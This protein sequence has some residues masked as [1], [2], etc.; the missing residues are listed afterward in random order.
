MEL[1]LNSKVAFGMELNKFLESYSR[2]LHAFVEK[3]SREKIMSSNIHQLMPAELI[4]RSQKFVDEF[5]EFNK[6]KMAEWVAL[7]NQ[8]TSIQESTKRAQFETARKKF[9]KPILK[10]LQ[11][12]NASANALLGDARFMGITL[13]VEEN[14]KEI[15]N[16]TLADLETSWIKEF[17]TP[18]S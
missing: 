9:W 8:Y 1:N 2:D 18:P 10:D 15:A 7:I 6:N 12:L 17:S 5:Q 4:K 16:M 3:N 13:P 11:A 14:L